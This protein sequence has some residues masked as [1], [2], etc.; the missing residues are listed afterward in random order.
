MSDAVFQFEERLSGRRV[1]LYGAGNAAVD[2]L[3]TFQARGV[4]V[5]CVCDGKKRGTFGSDAIPIISP[6]KLAHDYHDAVVIVSSLN[7][8]NEIFTNLI[9]LGFSRNQIELYPRAYVFEKHRNDYDQAYKFF[10]DE[11]SRQ[12]VMDRARFY[13][14][15]TPLEIN[16]TS[17][18][19]YEEGFITLSENEVFVDGGA[20]EGD[21]ALQFIDRANSRYAR[22]YA[23]EPD[24][25]NYG[26]AVRALSG[27]PAIEFIQKGLWSADT[28][29]FFAGNDA[30]RAASAFLT[31]GESD[32]RVPV[33]SLD[34][35][36]KDR[37][38]TEWPTFIKLDVEG[39]EKETLLGAA[40]IIRRSR[41][42]L[43]ISAYHKPEDLYELPRTI[44]GIRDD[45]RFCLRHHYAGEWD[46]IL[47]AA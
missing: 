26:K 6:E 46:T 24:A 37:P 21:S 42:K 36:L 38:D 4:A 33:I 27:F 18:R 17:P 29:L 34:T 7:Y 47:Y 5:T 35:F 43:A 1:V 31:S 14:D 41:P 40:E 11:R 19:Y 44:A 10:T 32:V 39:A 22:I 16:S 20:C 8:G 13:I 23:F 12:L 3:G 45:Y 28:E 9:G 2:L 30:D 25:V 15:G